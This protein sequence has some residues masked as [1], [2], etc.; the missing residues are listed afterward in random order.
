MDNIRDSIILT[1]NTN[2][3]YQR[4]LSFSDVQPEISGDRAFGA[5]SQLIGADMYD[6]NSVRGRLV[7]LRRAVREQTQ[8]TIL[9]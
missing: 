7:A 8:T 6:P 3:P 5:A 4:T 2:T 1:F 9:F